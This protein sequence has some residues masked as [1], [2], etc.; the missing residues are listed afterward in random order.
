MQVG[1]FLSLLAAIAAQARAD[2]NLVSHSRYRTNMPE[3]V[4]AVSKLSAVRVSEETGF[5]FFIQ[6]QHLVNRC[7][8]N[9]QYNT[10]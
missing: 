1:A 6:S 10:Y 4:F 3:Q 9:V 2:R 5:I 7:S 8:I